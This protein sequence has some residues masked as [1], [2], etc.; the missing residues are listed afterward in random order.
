M[1]P[2]R[3]EIP[4]ELEKAPSR[5]LDKPRVGPRI[6]IV[7]DNY[8]VAHQCERALTEAGYEVVDIV[9]TAQEAVRVA[10]ERRPELVLMDIYLPGTRDGIDAAI[11][12]FE[13]C[14]IRSIFASALADAGAKTRADAAQPLAWL[15]KPFNDKKLVATVSS[16]M[17][18]LEV[19]A[20]RA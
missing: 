15:A 3:I 17:A 10:I 9:M 4:H 7:E 16:A 14:R 19:I 1:K 8:F 20:S 11:E 13:R 5:V 12:I 18:H 6:L 2:L